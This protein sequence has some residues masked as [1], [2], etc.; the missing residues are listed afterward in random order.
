MHGTK[1]GM[2]GTRHLEVLPAGVRV[3]PLDGDAVLGAARGVLGAV[4]AVPASRLD[5]DAGAVKLA[6]VHFCGE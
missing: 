1:K 4:G 3:Q 5:D 2:T 6:S